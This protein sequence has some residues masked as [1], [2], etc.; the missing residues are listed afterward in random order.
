MQDGIFDGFTIGSK[1]SNYMFLDGNK[2]VKFI[3]GR[4]IV[5]RSSGGNTATVYFDSL[6]IPSQ[7]TDVALNHCMIFKKND[8]WAIGF[9]NDG[10]KDHVTPIY[11][12]DDNQGNIIRLGDGNR[13]VDLRVIEC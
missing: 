11:L 10:G 3:G 4:T 12:F 2:R 5:G 1:K 8:N 9:V 7:Y 13:F 6:L